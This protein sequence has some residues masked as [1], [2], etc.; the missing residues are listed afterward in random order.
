[1]TNVQSKILIGQDN[2]QLIIPRELIEGPPYAPVLSRSLLGW[3][4]HE[5]TGAQKYRVDS[6]INFHAW[7]V[8]THDELHNMIKDTF[9]IADFAVKIPAKPLNSHKE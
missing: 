1:M 8:N 2:Y 5:N 4:V 3:S 7:E 6:E 9:K